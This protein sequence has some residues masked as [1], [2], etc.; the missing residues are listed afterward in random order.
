MQRAIC[1][2]FLIQQDCKNCVCNTVL[3]VIVKEKGKV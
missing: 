2:S 1:Q 3:H